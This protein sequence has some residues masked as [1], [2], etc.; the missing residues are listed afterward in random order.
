[1]LLISFTLVRHQNTLNCNVE[2][3]LERVGL[4]SYTYMHTVNTV[5][6]DLNHTKQLIDEISIEKHLIYNKDGLYAKRKRE[7]NLN[8]YESSFFDYLSQLCTKKFSVNSLAV[9]LPIDNEEE[10]LTRLKKLLENELVHV[11]ALF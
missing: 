8:V 1:M 3:Q 7:I 2:F 10:F 5:G 6:F 11:S 4:N 9:Y